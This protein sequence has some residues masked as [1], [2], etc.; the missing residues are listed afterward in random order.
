MAV[1]LPTEARMQGGQP[2]DQGS[3]P[4]D[5]RSLLCN[6]YLL[7]HFYSPEMKFIGYTYNLPP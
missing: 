1:P 6:K 4:S 3:R 5:P 2:G 7:H